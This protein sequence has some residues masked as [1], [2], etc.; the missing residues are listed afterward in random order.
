MITTV[1]RTVIAWGVRDGWHPTVNQELGSHEPSI[2]PGWNPS[3][4]GFSSQARGGL[5]SEIIYAFSP[6]AHGGL[7]KARSDD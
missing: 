7:E 1:K 3:Q 2:G 6:Q 4:L 5:D